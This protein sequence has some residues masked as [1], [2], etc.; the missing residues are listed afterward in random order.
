MCFDAPGILIVEGQEETKFTVSCRDSHQVFC[1]ISQL[2][3]RTNCEEDI[4]LTPAAHKFVMVS[5]GTT[6]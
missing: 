4:C 5:M 6:R 2:K 1:F 3:N